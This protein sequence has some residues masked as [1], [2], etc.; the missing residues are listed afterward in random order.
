[1]PFESKL[2]GHIWSDPKISLFVRSK[3]LAA[4]GVFL[5]NLFLAAEEKVTGL[6]GFKSKPARA[7]FQVKKAHVVIIT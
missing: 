4:S 6:K 1:M 5:V 2:E 3:T 7:S